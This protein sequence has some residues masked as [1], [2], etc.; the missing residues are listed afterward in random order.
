M[1]HQINLNGS[2]KQDGFALLSSLIILFL[3]SALAVAIFYSTV[4]ERANSGTDLQKNTAYYASE[5]AME[6]MTSDLGNL[7]QTDKSPSILQINSVTNATYQPNISNA[8]YT[9]YN[10]QVTPDP[11]NAAMPASATSNISSGPNAGL[12]AEIIKMQLQATAITS[13][14]AGAQGSVVGLGEVRMSRNI[15]VALIP[16]FQFGI[17]SQNDLD[18]FNGPQFNFG[19]RVF[20]NGN[21]FLATGSG[22]TFTSKVQAVKQV[23]R[24][25]L[26]NGIA[27]ST[28]WNGPVSLPTAPN[29]CSGAA[30]ACRALAMGEESA[31][32]FFT[33]PPQGVPN[34]NWTKVSTVTYGGMLQDGATGVTPL[35]LPFV[36]GGVG[37]YEIIRRP[38]NAENPTSPT[39]SSRLYNQAQ[40]RILLDDNPANLP[41]GQ[42]V[43]LDV[44]L[45]S[46]S[47][48]VPTPAGP[49][50]QSMAQGI[51][52]VACP[53]VK[54]PPPPCSDP[55]WFN[56]NLPANVNNPWPLISGWLRVEYRD[57]NGVYHNVTQEWLNL[58][59]ARQ[60]Q[61]QA[62]GGPQPNLENG[63]G[64]TVNPNAILLF[65]FPVSQENRFTPTAPQYGWYPI[66]M[67]DPREG[68]TRD[69]VPGTTAASSCAIGGVMNLVELDMDNLRQWLLGKTGANGVNVESATQNGYIVYF[70]DRRGM[71]LDPLSTTGELNGEYGFNDVVNIADP[72]G[73]PNNKLDAGEDINGDGRLRVYGVATMGNGFGAAAANVNPYTGG[74][75]LAS[76]YPQARVNQVTGPRHAMRLVNGSLGHI[77]L[78]PALTGGTTVASENPVYVQGNYNS[79]AATGFGANGE[80]ASAVIADA[81]T[82]LSV[83]YTDKVG[84]QNPFQVGGRN[85]ATSFYRLAIASGKNPMFPA[86][87]T[88]VPS[89]NDYGT[90][91]GVHN[92]LRY[93]E[94]WGGQTLNYEGSLVS[95]YYSR[96]AVGAFKCCQVVYGA[97]ARNYAFDQNFLDPKQMPPGTPRFQDIDNLG[98]HQDYRPQ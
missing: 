72:A 11:K 67:Y 7:Y 40:I 61:E 27:A 43:G 78:T 51:V 95:F 28:N 98:Y 18:F 12:S 32:Q 48:T 21:L 16:V 47:A 38:P 20:T 56:P 77:P 79:N 89:S 90:D 15:E 2:S 35:N 31:T 52:P 88:W 76:C 91:G 9:E 45:A 25:V 39:G 69:P 97:P 17:F 42:Q 70:S 5:A 65:Q 53:G 33:A 73:A 83:K 41:K 6:K 64:N 96:Q 8:S 14:A 59:F 24:D 30:P 46:Y 60:A 10:I 87:I 34:P 36:N 93:V 13:G 54:V 68:E 3:L 71:Q 86:P 74:G 1:P 49:Q 23:V 80:A 57:T 92:F 81:V 94:N 22:L 50:V 84:L 29:G 66:N 26:A 55:S 85:A 37:P 19:G 4:S 63:I 75:R 82:L 44:N 58:G 62:P